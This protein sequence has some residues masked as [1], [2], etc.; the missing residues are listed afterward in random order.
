[1]K[2]RITLIAM[3]LLVGASRYSMAQEI[4]SSNGVLTTRN[5]YVTVG[6]GLRYKGVGLNGS[7]MYLFWNGL[8]LEPD[9]VFKVDLSYDISL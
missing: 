8:A 5:N 1:M 2:T 7:F 6:A 4:V 3:L 9:Y